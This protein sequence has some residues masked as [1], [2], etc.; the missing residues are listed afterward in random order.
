VSRSG[1]IPGRDDATTAQAVKPTESSSPA[2]TSPDP[3]SGA[4]LDVARAEG[5][6]AEVA[7][8]PA[9]SAATPDAPE[10]PPPA[11]ES[12]PSPA[13]AVADEAPADAPP[14]AAE[15]APRDEPALQDAEPAGGASTEPPI[16][17]PAANEAQPAAA[18]APPA[19]E[20]RPVEA[21]PVETVAA[22]PGEGEP[23]PAAETDAPKEASKAE[24]AVPPREPEPERAAPS[25]KPQ[26][27]S[28]APASR[29]PASRMTRPPVSRRGHHVPHGRSLGTLAIAALGVVYGDIGTSP[30][31]ALRECF[32]GEHALAVNQTNVLGILSLIFWSLTIIVSLKYLAYVLRADNRG[33]G[34]VLA[35]MALALGNRAGSRSGMAVIALGLFGAALLY[36]DGMITPAISVLSAVEGLEI[37]T[38][39]FA[40]FVV[41]T[42]VAILALLFLAQRF[43]TAK[44][45]AVFGP[46]MLLWFT[47]LAALGIHHIVE[48]PTI[49]RAV[50]PHHAVHFMVENGKVGFL[51][52]GSV[53]LV[54]TGGEALYADMGHFGARPIRLTWMALVAPA[55]MLNYLGQGALLLADPSAASHPFFRTAPAWGLIPLVILA[56]LATI[57]ASQALI[58]GAY[59]LTRQATMLGF[60]PRVEIQHTSFTEIGQIYVPSINWMLMIATIALVLGFGSSSKLAA[61]YG[62]AVTTTMVI[63]TLLAYVVARQRW[64]WS[65][66][67]AGA[68]TLMFVCVDLAFFGANAVKIAHG[69][70]VPLVIGGV[71]F[72]LMTT[73]KKG[74][75]IL[76]LRMR[77]NMIPLTD[78]FELIRIERPARVPGTAVFMTSNADGTPPALMQNF[79]HNRVVHQQ[80]ILLTV[81]TTEQP[82]VMPD[83]RVKVE[84]LPEGF[85]RVVARYGFMEQ[86]DIPQL[87]EER[88]LEDW[89]VE[90]T[91]F[92][93]GRET[94]LATKERAG[95]AI[96]REKL[97]AF[98]SRNSQRASTFFNVPSD[99]V[100]E[101]GS[102]I[103]L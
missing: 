46:V 3:E 22:T 85:R 71:I 102:Q 1:E 81:V 40:R 89:S 38:P 86:P 37:A 47:T 91:T 55:L 13:P 103:E 16:E 23:E 42:T 30:L 92:F 57:I 96:W 95:M 65:P 39:A 5:P 36:G 88:H 53:F 98:M 29:G 48:H 25:D 4:A 68:L 73:W 20:P 93:L 12:P 27:P 75:E 43:G 33:E 76:G 2:P 60:W 41:P 52:L 35:L 50:L 9:A 84:D 32:H 10:A 64:G 72:A 67:A 18:G 99:R 79:T 74:R 34:G 82:R 59:S 24:A 62:I 56:T 7:S 77:E 31:Y 11:A 15:S 90:H 101:V 45:G 21:L 61:A 78:F 8:A 6:A 28:L 100:M 17:S 66:L 70:W 54:V 58:S 94:L 26:K 69:G 51:V 14:P 97:F 63:T 44:V 49:F 87:L 83:E 19:G 80:V